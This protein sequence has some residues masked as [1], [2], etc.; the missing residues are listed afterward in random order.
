[1]SA[2]CTEEQFLRD[3]AEHEMIVIRDDG[4]GRHIRF[5]RPGTSCMHFDLIT[6]PGYLC[7]TG[8]MGTYVSQRL[9]DMFE[10]FRTDREYKKRNGAQLAVNL[11]YWGEKLQ[12]TDHD[13]YRK[14]SADKFRANVMDWIE[15]CGLVGKLG[16]GL[17][18]ELESEVL[19]HADDGSDAAYSAAMRF[20]WAGKRVFAEFYE[21][22]SEDYTHRFVWCCYALAWGIEKYDASKQPAAEAVPA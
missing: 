13:G 15:Q 16:H 4:I 18:E 10:F 22:D 14:Y 12:A 2:A 21:L 9:E 6:W 5:K 1:M 8:D 3:V 20:V 7:Y 17:R 11:R 19:D